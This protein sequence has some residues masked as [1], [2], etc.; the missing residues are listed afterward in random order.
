MGISSKL[1]TIFRGDLTVSDLPRELLRR[2]RAAVRQKTERRNLHRLNTAPARLSSELES[3]PTAELLTRFHGSSQSFFAV[4][5]ADLR[6]RLATAQVEMFPDETA[7]VIAS[8][9]RIVRDSTWE[10]AGFGPLKFGGENAW[11]TDPLGKMDWG[12]DYHADVAVFQ[13]NGADIRVLWELN[14]FGHA[15]TLARAFVVTNDEDYAETFFLHIESWM[16]QNPYGCGA[17]W[18]CAMGVSL[19]AI[20]LLAALDLLRL[21]KSCTEERFIQIL[22]LFDQHGR[23]ISD[24][25]EFSYISTSNH[26][27]SNVVG[28]FWI[29]VLRPELEHAR[30]WRDFG[31]GEMLCEMDV[32]ILSDGAD[33]EASTGYHKFVTE[34][35]LYTFLL[36]KRNDIEI[37]EKYWKKLGGML[38]YLVEIIRP[39]GPIPLI[40]DADGSQIVPI[41]TRDAN[42][43]VYLL[44]LGAVCFSNS[45]FKTSPSVSPEILWLFGETGVETFHTLGAWGVPSASAA[46]P[47]AGAYILRD[48]DLYLHFNANDCG[49]NGRGSHGHNDALSIEVSALGRPFIVDPGSYVYNLDR[50]ERHRFRSTAYH[51]TVTVDDRDQSSIDVDLP[52]IIGNQARPEARLMVPAPDQDSI[53][54]EHFG[55]RRLANPIGHR[56]TVQ[57]YKMERYWIVEDLLGGN[58]VHD[59]SFR[60]HLAPGL[61]VDPCCQSAVAISD[62]ERRTLYIGWRG[63][64]APADTVPAFVSRNYGHRENSIILKWNMTAPA[65][66]TT[67]FVLMPCGPDEN[68]SAKLVVLKSLIG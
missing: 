40:G 19:R 60:F 43:A 20:N 21:S 49:V 35:L 10:L 50:E 25:S 61:R 26:Y 47:E 54:G 6:G 52:F 67:R 65:P 37:P 14:R 59:F 15:I 56:R 13:P 68:S 51:S 31:L 66:V 30:Q 44:S 12:T 27:L 8:A 62:R 33:F 1:R 7:L 64:D 4:D 17:N 2:R 11:R 48:N 3:M 53:S 63:V 42:D 34:M 32:Q 24:N 16:R 55:Y 45:K 36:A 9:D 46:F 5:H 29:G 39:D 57:F 23:F 28:L 18:N 41:V 22:R 38:E 58:G